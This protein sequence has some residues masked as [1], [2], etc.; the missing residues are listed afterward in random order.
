MLIGDQRYWRDRAERSFFATFHSRVSRSL[1]TELSFFDS[2]HIVRF[3]YLYILLLLSIQPFLI[4]YI[5]HTHTFRPATRNQS[6]DNIYFG[7]TTADREQLHVG[8]TDCKTKERR[9][10]IN[11]KRGDDRD[12]YKRSEVKEE[13]NETSY[14]RQDR[15]LLSQALMSYRVY[16]L[17]RYIYIRQTNTC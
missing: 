2:R 5:P 15:Y 10:Q 14:G 17:L 1:R 4:I 16:T 6:G 13:R 7:K 11:R 12:V 3:S 9:K 8:C